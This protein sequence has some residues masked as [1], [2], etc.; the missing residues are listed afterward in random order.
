M[1]TPTAPP[2]SLVASAPIFIINGDNLSVKGP[3]GTRLPFTQLT[4]QELGGINS[5]VSVEQYLS[6][7]ATGRV[8]HTKQMGLTKP[9]SVT[10]KRGIDSNLTLWYWHQMSLQGDTTARGD[11]TLDMYGGGSPNVNSDPPAPK[12]FSYTLHHA[13]CA[14][15]NISGAKAGEGFV[16]EDVV[17]ACDEI[18]AN[19]T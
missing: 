9:P 14:K 17:I 13:W 8:A 11:I 3:N 12:L 16:T 19:P 18:T 4:F 7:D 2:F 6:V 10:L 1:P 15:I 5:E